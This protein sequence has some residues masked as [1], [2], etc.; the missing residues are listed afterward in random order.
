MHYEVGTC[1]RTCVSRKSHQF[2]NFNGPIRMQNYSE[3][4]ENRLSSSGISITARMGEKKVHDWKC[5]FVD[6]KQ[7]LFFSVY[8]DDINIA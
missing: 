7:G 6:R 5:L 8:V 4:T 1:K 2:N 3:L